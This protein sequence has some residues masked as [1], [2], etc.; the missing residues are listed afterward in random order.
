MSG[1]CLE[2]M[3]PWRT[4]DT[5]YRTRGIPICKNMNSELRNP[6]QSLGHPEALQLKMS[7]DSLVF[8]W[9][10]SNKTWT[11]KQACVFN[12]YCMWQT[13]WWPERETQ[14]KRCHEWIIGIIQIPKNTLKNGIAGVTKDFWKTPKGLATE[15]RDPKSDLHGQRYP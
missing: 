1:L 4:N 3:F 9:H 10:R 13:S 14:C 12:V 5:L 15:I 6:G 2:N 7:G 11:G 8:W